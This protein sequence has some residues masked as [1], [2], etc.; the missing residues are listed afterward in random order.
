MENLG[1]IFPLSAAIM[2]APK[3]RGFKR[4]K[5]YRKKFNSRLSS[6][7]YYFCNLHKRCSPINIDTDKVGVHAQGYTAE[8]WARLTALKNSRS[9]NVNRHRLH[10]G[11]PLKVS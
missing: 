7:G 10:S 9:E 11:E 4:P 6:I 8:A 3:E 1:L 2:A 5:E